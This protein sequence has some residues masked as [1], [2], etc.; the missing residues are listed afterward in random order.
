[1]MQ[2]ILLGELFCPSVYF[3]VYG[4]GFAISVFWN[5]RHYEETHGLPRTPWPNEALNDVPF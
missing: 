5:W 2:R 3:R 4:A 1:M